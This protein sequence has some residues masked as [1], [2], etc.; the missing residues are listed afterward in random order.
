MRAVKYVRWWYNYINGIFWYSLCLIPLIKICAACFATSSISMHP[1]WNS[2]M[3]IMHTFCP[4]FNEQASK[5]IPGAFFL[6]T[7]LPKMVLSVKSWWD[8]FRN[9]HWSS[10]SKAFC[11]EW[12]VMGLHTKCEAYMKSCGNLN[13]FSMFVFFNRHQGFLEEFFRKTE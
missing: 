7:M 11:F 5:L 10:I 9:H 1:K 3:N 12:Y 13:N 4:A 6:S 8:F 2:L